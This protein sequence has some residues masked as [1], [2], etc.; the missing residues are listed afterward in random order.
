MPIN[1]NQIKK[2]LEKR[3]YSKKAI[4]EIIRWYSNN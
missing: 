1:R 2:D 3:G 4:E